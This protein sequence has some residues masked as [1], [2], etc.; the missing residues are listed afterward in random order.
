MIPFDPAKPFITSG[1][2][3]GTPA[4]TTRGLKED[5]MIFIAK[6]IDEAVTNRKDDEVLA[7]IAAKVKKCIVKHP[8]PEF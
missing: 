1:I 3:I 6:C 2:R 7:T 8:M 5:D 4:V